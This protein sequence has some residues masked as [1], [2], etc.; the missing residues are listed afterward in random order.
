M[1]DPRISA[2]SCHDSLRWKTCGNRKSVDA[3]A[4][5]Q[6]RQV[7]IYAQNEAGK[8]DF[9]IKWIHAMQQC[10]FHS[11]SFTGLLIYCHSQ[12]WWD[13]KHKDHAK[14]QATVSFVFTQVCAE[15]ESHDLPKARFEKSCKAHDSVSFIQVLQKQT[16]CC[17]FFDFVLEISAA[18]QHIH[19]SH[20]A[21]H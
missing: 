18:Y 12:E 21:I 20:T 1:S 19:T 16:H 4:K 9:G 3:K 10:M 11:H 13:K 6:E 14:F 5:F 7:R 17:V 15:S 8:V 2:E